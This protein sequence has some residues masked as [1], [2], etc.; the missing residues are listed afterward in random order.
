MNLNDKIKKHDGIWT[1]DEANANTNILYDITDN[2]D[3]DNCKG[4]ISIYI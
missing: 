4:V 2:T 1:R 3:G